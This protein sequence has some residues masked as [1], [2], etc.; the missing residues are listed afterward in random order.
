MLPGKLI[1]LNTYLRKEGRSKID[2]PSFLFEKLEEEGRFKPTAMDPLHL[3]AVPWFAGIFTGNLQQNRDRNR[4]T[5]KGE[6][7]PSF[8]GRCPVFRRKARGHNDS[9]DGPHASPA[10]GPEGQYF[11]GQEG[12]VF[13]AESECVRLCPS[14]FSA[15]SP[16]PPTAHLAC[17]PGLQTWLPSTGQLANLP[18]ARE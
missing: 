2:T 13:K 4:K 10:C 12:R 1:V 6:D 3:P 7:A 8:R 18:S 5:G 9:L 11:T 14:N 17:T 15:L 16:L